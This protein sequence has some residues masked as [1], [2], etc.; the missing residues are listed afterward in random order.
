MKAE[1]QYQRCRFR[2]DSRQRFEP[3]Q[4]LLGRQIVEKIDRWRP[5]FGHDLIQHCFDPRCLDLGP[6]CRRNRLG[7]PFDWRSADGLP[8]AVLLPEPVKRFRLVGLRGA[9]RKNG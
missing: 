5:A 7:Y 3:G 4:P 6:V 1:Q 8:A 2:A 9:M